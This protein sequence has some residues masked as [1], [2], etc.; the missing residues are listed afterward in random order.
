ML[1]L[2]RFSLRC[3]SWSRHSKR[4]FQSRNNH[5]LFCTNPKSPGRSRFFIGSFPFSTTGIANH[6]HSG[7]CDAPIIP[8]RSASRLFCMYSTVPGTRLVARPNAISTS[9]GPSPDTPSNCHLRNMADFLLSFESSRRHTRHEPLCF[10]FRVLSVETR[11]GNNDPPSLPSSNTV[12]SHEAP[13]VL[14]SHR[15]RS[16]FVL[17]S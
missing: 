7:A 2:C 6:L 12:F 16:P 17:S 1:V 15:N 5:H 10:R 13:D 4:V 8:L 14:Q 3:I 9:P 11:T